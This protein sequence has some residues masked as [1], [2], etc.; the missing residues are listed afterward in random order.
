MTLLAVYRDHL[1]LPGRLLTVE[2]LESEGFTRDYARVLLHRLCKQ[3]AAMPAGASRVRLLAPGQ[4]T[5]GLAPSDS[6]K[7]VLA[8]RFGAKQTG[9]SVLPKRYPVPRPDEFLVPRSKLAAAVEM[10]HLKYPKLKVSVDKYQSGKDTVCL[11]PA[12]VRGQTATP[13]EALMHVYRHAPRE[14]FTLA[15]QALLMVNP[16]LHW[17]R[18]RTQK[19]WP[20]LAGVFVAVNAQAGHKVFPAFRTAEPPDLTYNQLGTVA[21]AFT[22]RGTKA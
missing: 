14:D 22:A 13:E 11:Y 16:K 17:S 1:G 4:H 6:W 21:Q 19:E 18:L 10:L 9:F 15:L 7:R 20:E 3:G 2:Q 12:R 5:P 8:Q